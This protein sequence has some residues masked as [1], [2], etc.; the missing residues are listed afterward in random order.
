M[1][2]EGLEEVE[3]YSKTTDKDGKLFKQVVEHYTVKLIETWLVMPLK[4][5]EL[6]LKI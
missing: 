3:A 5:D 6:T 1:D 4:E 2:W